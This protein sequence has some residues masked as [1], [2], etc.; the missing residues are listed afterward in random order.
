MAS[1]Y[2]TTKPTT[3]D[4]GSVH[5]RPAVATAWAVFSVY[6]E[7]LYVA[8][9]SLA[10]RVADR[11]ESIRFMQTAKRR[12]SMSKRKNRF[13]SARF[14]SWV[15]R[16]SATRF[17]DSG[18]WWL[19]SLKTATRCSAR[20]RS[21]APVCIRNAAAA[22]DDGGAVRDGRH[23]TT[24][25]DPESATR[26]HSEGDASARSSTHTVS[27]RASARTIVSVEP[28]VL[29][30]ILSSSTRTQRS[31]GRSTASRRHGASA[32]RTNSIIFTTISIRM[33]SYALR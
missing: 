18:D 10:S 20:S 22:G 26:R 23:R 16:T 30:F 8:R 12:R 2:Y 1:R 11:H 4:D 14:F 6:G 21:L 5:E 9:A 3:L 29:N 32:S 31:S 15:R 33:A 7:Y 25:G 17:F 27:T 19:R 13:M 28:S 24:A